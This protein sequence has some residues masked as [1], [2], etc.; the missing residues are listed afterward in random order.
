MA[1]N[2]S[3]KLRHSVIQRYPDNIRSGMKG[4]QTVGW[5]IAMKIIGSGR[6]DNVTNTNI[7]HENVTI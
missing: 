6:N 4:A 3:F 5:G 7:R 2:E 1:L